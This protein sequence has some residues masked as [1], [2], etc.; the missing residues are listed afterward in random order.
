LI[1]NL[2]KIIKELSKSNSL[3]SV[4]KDVYGDSPSE[5]SLIEEKH[6]VAILINKIIENSQGYSYSQSLLNKLYRL[7]LILFVDKIKN[8]S[9]NAK[10][11]AFTYEKNK[12][13]NTISNAAN[14]V[15]SRSQDAPNNL[16]DVREVINPVLR[17][18]N[19]I[20]FDQISNYPNL[21]F[22]RKSPAFS[23]A[24]SNFLTERQF[25]EILA[26]RIEEGQALNIFDQN[27][28]GFLEKKKI[29]A[30][31][32][33]KIRDNID[34][35]NTS[36]S[37]KSYGDLKKR[38][39]D[40]LKK[41]EVSLEEKDYDHLNTLLSDYVLSSPQNNLFI[42]LEGL[43]E[44]FL[45]DEKT[46]TRS[47]PI[48]DWDTGEGKSFFVENIL[49][50]YNDIISKFKAKKGGQEKDTL[51]HV[52]CKGLFGDITDYTQEEIT[53]LVNNKIGISVL[54]KDLANK[55]NNDEIENFKRKYDL[56]G[57]NAQDSSKFKEGLERLLKQYILAN[58]GFEIIKC[59]LANKERLKELAQGQEEK[60]KNKVFV[61]DES[62]FIEDA[63]DIMQQIVNKGGKV[64]RVGASVN[65]FKT[66]EDNYQKP[67]KDSEANYENA[68]EAEEITKKALKDLESDQIKAKDSNDNENLIS[69]AKVA[70]SKKALENIKN[71]R[72]KTV[73][74]ISNT[75]TAIVNSNSDS[76]KAIKEKLKQS[77]TENQVQYL[78]PSLRFELDGQNLTEADQDLLKA[79]AKENPNH[80]VMV[81]LIKDQKHHIAYINPNDKETI[82]IIEANE[83][84]IKTLEAL[85]QDDKAIMIYAGDKEFVV[86]GDYGKY[87]VLGQRAKQVL[88]VDSKRADHLDID[89]L[90]QMIGRNRQTDDTLKKNLKIEI[91]VFGDSGLSK[92]NFLKQCQENSYK[93]DLGGLVA[94]L[95][96]KL[97]KNSLPE[98]FLSKSLSDNLLGFIQGRS[99]LFDYKNPEKMFAIDSFSQ[100]QENLLKDS[101]F[102]VE[103]EDE[104]RIEGVL[105]DK[106]KPKSVKFVGK[107]EYDINDYYPINVPL[108]RDNLRRKFISE[109]T[110]LTIKG[111]EFG[112]LSKSIQLSIDS[113]VNDE[114]KNL[115]KINRNY[116]SYLFYKSIQDRTFNLESFQAQINN[117]Q[118][119]IG[120]PIDNYS[121]YGLSQDLI[122]AIKQ[123]E[124]IYKKDPKKRIFDLEHIENLTRLAH[125]KPTVVARF[126]KTIKA[127]ADLILETKRNEYLEK[128][129]QEEIAR[130]EESFKELAKAINEKLPIIA[131]LVKDNNTKKQ[132]S[133]AVRVVDNFFKLKQ[134]SETKLKGA[135]DNLKQNKEFLEKLQKI[136]D[137]LND[138]VVSIA[139][140]EKLKDA[141]DKEQARLIAE[142][143]E[144]ID[145]IR[146]QLEVDKKLIEE[147]LK[148]EHK[149]EIDKLKEQFEQQKAK[150]ESEL[151]SASVEEIEELEE[152]LKSELAQE[153]K[154]AEEDY[155]TKLKEKIAELQSKTEQ[156]IADIEKNNLLAL[157]LQRKNLL[158]EKNKALDDKQKE[159]NEL[160]DQI[161]V[162]NNK[163]KE[164]ESLNFVLVKKVES[165]EDLNEQLINERKNL[166]DT[167][168]QNKT[169]IQTKETT[170]KE[171]EATLKLRNAISTNQNEE[172][173]KLKREIE[174]LKKQNQDLE[175]EKER[176]EGE[177]KS[178]DAEL[179]RNRSLIEN[180]SRQIANL[181]VKNKT[182]EESLE[183]ITK[184]KNSLQEELDK[185]R[186]EASEEETKFAIETQR[187][188]LEIE[189]VKNSNNYL[190][191]HNEQIQARIETL[192]TEKG[193]VEVDLAQKQSLLVELQKSLDD[194]E[195]KN[196]EKDEEIGQL[197]ASN[198][199][200]ERQKQELTSKITNLENEV[201]TLRD[202][203]T[204]KDRQIATLE[205]IKAKNEQQQQELQTQLNNFQQEQ[206]RLK[207][208]EPKIAELNLQLQKQ[209]EDFAKERRD[210][211]KQLDD[212][213]NSLRKNLASSVTDVQAKRA[214]EA[215][216]AKQEEEFK[217]K[218]SQAEERSKKQKDQIIAQ[219]AAL[220][221]SQISQ[222]TQQAELKKALEEIAKFK[223]II[224]KQA[225]SLQASNK[226]AVEA[227]LIADEVI[228][229]ADEDRLSSQ[230]RVQEQLLQ[231]DKE[232]ANF[233]AKL[234]AELKARRAELEEE[235]KNKKSVAERSLEI[236]K[237]EFAKLQSTLK[238]AV[239]KNSRLDFLAE[240]QRARLQQIESEL[241]ARKK[242]E[243]DLNAQLENYQQRNAQLDNN[244][245]ARS[246]ELEAL[247]KQLQ[248]QATNALSSDQAQQQLRS[249]ILKVQE[250]VKQVNLQKQQ[251]EQEILQLQTQIAGVQ[252]VNKGFVVK[253]KELEVL[254]KRLRDAESRQNTLKADLEIKDK[255]L[256]EF[257]GQNDALQQEKLELEQKNQA[258]ENAQQSLNDEIALLRTA[259]GNA[260]DQIVNSK[261]Q[262]GNLEE[263]KEEMLQKLKTAQDDIEQTQ[264]ELKAKLVEIKDGSELIAT[265]GKQIEDLQALIN[266]D[267]DA[268]QAEN[269][270]L[271]E[272]IRGL[273]TEIAAKESVVK[274]VNQ[275]VALI[276]NRIISQEKGLASLQADIVQKDLTITT[277]E[278]KA[279][280]LEEEKQAFENKNKEVEEQLR[281]NNERL[282]FSLEDVK[283][284]EQEIERLKQSLKQQQELIATT[285]QEI[286]QNSDLIT[287][288][289][290]DLEQFQTQITTL[291][292]EN[293]GLKKAL[294]DKEDEELNLFLDSIF[295]NDA[296]N[297]LNSMVAQLQKAL[298]EQALIFDEQQKMA[299][300]DVQSSLLR[301][302]EQKDR[303]I[304]ELKEKMAKLLRLLSGDDNENLN[305]VVIIQQAFRSYLQKKKLAINNSVDPDLRSDEVSSS[306]GSIPLSRGDEV[307]NPENS[308][309]TISPSPTASLTGSLGK[310]A[311][312]QIINTLNTN[313]KSKKDANLNYE[314][315]KRD[316]LAQKIWFNNKKLF[317]VLVKLQDLTEEKIEDFIKDVNKGI[318]GETKQSAKGR[319]ILNRTDN[320]QR[321][322]INAGD[323]TV[324]DE[325]DDIKRN[326]FSDG[327]IEDGRENLTKILE[328]FVSNKNQ[329][330]EFAKTNKQTEQD[331]FKIELYNEINNPETSIPS[332]SPRHPKLVLKA[333]KE[334]A[335]D[336]FY[337]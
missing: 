311:L 291:N 175:N 155:E 292:A 269:F 223:E 249:Q 283:N 246:N 33:R 187:L 104:L 16:F 324:L 231:K 270:R 298:D 124:E 23:Q 262:L 267:K 241:E 99:V 237:Q 216:I 326:K 15:F 230:A 64:V 42:Q 252:E 44:E 172:I 29:D 191:E 83:I 308:L 34:T 17:K 335:G 307:D 24:Q 233:Q 94:N 9:R 90:K 62:F 275:D 220:M 89:L 113:G 208:I 85:R 141:I 50:K 218:I 71:R 150:F 86:G 117:N 234:E 20:E 38:I 65:Y 178:K 91:N 142:Q 69:K 135:G 47:K 317:N 97:R 103:Y 43:F 7:D 265:L 169:E 198:N 4:I 87:S 235:F 149:K 285:S 13:L 177:I 239:D 70:I 25:E 301:Q 313:T 282:L 173:N 332:P 152:K 257:E 31:T 146:K 329:I 162:V 140:E 260:G 40:A 66:L 160:F 188:Q 147:E 274:E 185:L 192:I 238:E 190:T 320:L 303:E 250:D 74:R 299:S 182:L 290:R 296:E 227:K 159:W 168:N 98:D 54:T 107:V 213:Q 163:I 245:L 51:E 201:K 68:I 310:R 123:K 148:S 203:I 304:K 55:F 105:V 207:G 125:A 225:E 126:Q 39:I 12:W 45:N 95:E 100:T 179:G 52:F 46:K 261:N 319:K 164:I 181:E 82:N 331:Y 131:N 11:I 333:T 77:I 48:L 157:E 196:I 195:N 264:A 154:K 254:E 106:G 240:A 158:A 288:N 327:A 134:N 56:I 186:V 286:A 110:N 32:I 28:K 79:I 214:L 139:N 137:I 306:D 212:L 271:L 58:K 276:Q 53:K 118:Y 115:I 293:E 284:K 78:I 318:F 76:T 183:K 244:L 189:T 287:N 255:K 6:S 302:G 112:N 204:S 151:E 67:L 170:I 193:A 197:R 312:E 41:D 49:D 247:Q 114:I 174:V 217:Q 81:N 295:A 259:I 330:I 321:F 36:F 224:E 88:F 73:T 161:E 37:I 59:N 194:L 279:S 266:N 2:E 30:Q 19:A 75:N 136:A 119:S 165:L 145:A 229:M 129:R 84:G 336:G 297:E 138:S 251:L 328:A 128:V 80:L 219:Q 268:N 57:S 316:E 325:I 222:S 243:E 156:R 109:H 96:R 226:E 180:N 101:D 122:E 153:L 167:I 309:P 166:N 10:E 60:V 102:E 130:S 92:E 72:E 5:A 14:Q 132:L 273:E 221:A 248:D 120:N 35:N 199:E 210:L 143:E 258:L 253:I 171:L 116:R 121:D 300:Q 236:Q 26:R 315:Y 3:E 314:D 206:T 281:Q 334:R 8:I 176:L 202:N 200:Y 22:A 1:E 232:I 294:K 278:E 27:I 280:K 263:E 272:Q 144:A 133:D 108:L 323:I 18:A 289:Q 209:Q 63:N 277:L 242:T 215:Q 21:P 111:K 127:K 228:G 211:E 184:E 93:K 61:I 256:K 205:E 337:L 305:S 322:D